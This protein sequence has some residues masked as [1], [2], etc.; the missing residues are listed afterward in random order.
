MTA[1]TIAEGHSI[2]LSLLSAG[3]VGSVD[4]LGGKVVTVVKFKGKR[5]RMNS[6]QNAMGSYAIV[7]KGT[8]QW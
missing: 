1:A 3:K 7:H 5:R 4:R 2:Y 6:K 8:K